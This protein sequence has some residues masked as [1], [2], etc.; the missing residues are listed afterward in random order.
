MTQQLTFRGF[1][2]TSTGSVF[3]EFVHLSLWWGLMQYVVEELCV[4]GPTSCNRDHS[5]SL[6]VCR[7]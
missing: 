4:C 6:S 2:A 5:S 3:R 7:Q 1:R